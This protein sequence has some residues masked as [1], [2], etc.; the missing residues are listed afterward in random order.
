MYMSPL[1]FCPL[2]SDNPLYKSANQEFQNPAY[3]G[4]N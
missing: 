1:F 3:G 4:A 2:Q